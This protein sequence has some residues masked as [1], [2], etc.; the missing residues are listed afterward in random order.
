MLEFVNKYNDIPSII[1]KELMQTIVEQCVLPWYSL[2]SISH[3]ARVFE[4]GCQLAQQTKAKIEVVQLF[5]VFHDAKRKHDGRD[6]R[7][8]QRGAEY[9]ASLRCI[10]FNLSDEDF[11]LLYTA[12]THHTGNRTVSN[13][14]TIQTCWDAD[15]LDLG[16]VGI[17]PNPKY[18]CTE[19]A[20]DSDMIYWATQ[21]ARKHFS[22][23]WIYKK[24]GVSIAK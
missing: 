21:R 10:L 1:S 22:P 19:P 12:C 24:W 8:G 2:H 17:L 6:F 13:D 5:A 9:A 7:H 14:V 3:W 20:K 16:R 11:N 23:K 18:L 4:N 15:R